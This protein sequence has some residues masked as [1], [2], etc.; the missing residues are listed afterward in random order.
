MAADVNE[1]AHVVPAKEGHHGLKVAFLE[2]VPARPQGRGGSPP[3]P[4]QCGLALSAQ[5]HQLVPEDTIHTVKGAD[6][7][8]RADGTGIVID[9][10]FAYNPSCAYNEAWACPL[11]PPG[12]VLRVEVPV[13]LPYSGAP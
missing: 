9:F 10:N 13:G 1:V 11:A 4:V 3:Y 6:L 12:N 7:G 2:L 8:T 5:V